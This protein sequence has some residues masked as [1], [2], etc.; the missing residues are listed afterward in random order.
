MKGTVSFFKLI[1]GLTGNGSK[2]V[3]DEYQRHY[4]WTKER[5]INLLKTIISANEKVFIG[6]FTI[7]APDSS[8][9][10]VVDGQ[11]RLVT[12]Y[13]IMKC[14]RDI[15]SENRETYDKIFSLKNNHVT[16][17]YLERAYEDLID[18]KYS[19]EYKLSFRKKDTEDDFDAVIRNN[20]PPKYKN[21]QIAKNYN[22]IKNYLLENKPE[23][24]C[25]AYLHLLNTVECCSMECDSQIE[26]YRTFASINGLGQKVEDKYSIINI[27][28]QHLGRANKDVCNLIEDADKSFMNRFLFNKTG[29][30][31]GRNDVISNFTNYIEGKNPE[32]VVEDIILFGEFDKECNNY[33]AK[34]FLMPVPAMRVVLN[35]LKS[36]NFEDKDILRYAKKFSTVFMRMQVCPGVCHVTEENIAIFLSK[37]TN[38]EEMEN[39]FIGVKEGGEE[40]G[41]LFYPK[42]EKFKECLKTIDIYHSTILKNY[43]LQAINNEL[44]DCEQFIVRDVSVEHILPQRD[45]KDNPLLHMIGNLTLTDVS[46]NSSMGVKDFSKKK[47]IL[48]NSVYALNRYFKDIDEWTDDEIIKR[49]EYLSEIAA[50]I[51]NIDN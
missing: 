27:I 12:V 51:W 37:I 18:D 13:I 26:A 4:V 10:Q 45:N 35:Y 8:E 47:E 33:I 25:N 39:F 30:W 15:M 22:A 41:R 11:Q 16:V 19:G 50:K 2:L 23:V 38:L 36:S 3:I 28:F 7:F 43:I 21:S 49:S 42:D 5:A 40:H 24:L 46:K 48:A 1:Q 6:T 32:M 29:K 20:R 34:N 44:S 14:L 31:V 17:Q 9:V